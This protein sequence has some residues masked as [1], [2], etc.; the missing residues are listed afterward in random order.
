MGFPLLDHKLAV[1]LAVPRPNRGET[2]IY[3]RDT[4]PSAKEFFPFEKSRMLEATS[5]LR[6]SS[7]Q[8]ETFH[9]G[10]GNVAAAPTGLRTEGRRKGS[11]LKPTQLGNEGRNGVARV[12]RPQIAGQIW[13][14][15]LWRHSSVFRGRNGVDRLS[16]FRLFH[17][18]SAH[19]C[20]LLGDHVH[21]IP[22]CWMDFFFH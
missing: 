11:I 2:A 16:H 13:P 1:W 15:H 4:Q 20:L 17:T 18:Q 12:K 14:Q 10:G 21:S 19:L 7:G 6:N 9:S 3:R 8:L 5:R 22:H